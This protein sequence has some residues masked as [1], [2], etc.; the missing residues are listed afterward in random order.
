MLTAQAGA[1]HWRPLAPLA[2]ALQDAG[3][4]V[5]FAV[6]PYSCD[7]IGAY[8]FRCFPVGA[9][10]WLKP[11][12]QPLGVGRQ[13]GPPA[14]AAEVAR[15]V[16][17]P[18]AARRLPAT[19]ALAR[20]WRPDLIVRE[21]TEYAGCLVAE[22]LGIPHVV[23]QISAWRGAAADGPILPGLDRL[24]EGLGLPPDPQGEMLYR[25]LLLLPIPPPSCRRPPASSA[26][27]ASIATFVRRIDCR[28]GS[29][30]WARCRRCMRRWGPPTTARRASSRRSSRGYGVSRSI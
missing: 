7:E 22:R 5:A 18:H 19:L 24:R 25:H 30:R 13:A 14:Q 15:D 16:F 23:F 8:G 27:S 12:E 6:T 28:A 20:E 1:G 26:T 11:K 9:D 3:H 2:R 17:L 21:Q 10:D 29:I 4:E